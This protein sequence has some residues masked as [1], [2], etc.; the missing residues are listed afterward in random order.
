MVTAVALA[1]QSHM[2]NQSGLCWPS[3]K[4]R[5]REART[6]VASVNRAVRLMREFGWLEWSLRPE[7]RSNT[8]RPAVPREIRW[9]LALVKVDRTSIEKGR[10]LMTHQ[11]SYGPASRLNLMQ[12]QPNSPSNSKRGSVVLSPEGSLHAQPG[13]RVAEARRLAVAL[14]QIECLQVANALGIPHAADWRPSAFQVITASG[15][16]RTLV[17]ELA[18]KHGVGT[19]GSP[20]ADTTGQVDSDKETH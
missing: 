17:E 1:L 6:S 8:Y 4:T 9:M 15:V 18:S 11:A 5:A 16:N 12:D 10:R 3:Q 14:S 13:I 2:D 20:V 19:A 7:R